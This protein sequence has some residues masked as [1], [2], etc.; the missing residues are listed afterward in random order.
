M[1]GR[2]RIANTIHRNDNFVGRDGAPHPPIV[3][4]HD[5][6]VNMA[7]MLKVC[8]AAHRFLTTPATSARIEE[9]QRLIDALQRL[10][11]EAI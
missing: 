11:K 3:P 4:W 7:L 1:N 6:S 9:G 8:N 2:E 10:D 5:V